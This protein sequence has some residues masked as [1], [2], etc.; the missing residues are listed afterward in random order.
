MVSAVNGAAAFPLPPLFP[1]AAPLHGILWPTA[2]LAVPVP[3]PL[4]VVLQGN[5]W[6]VVTQLTGADLL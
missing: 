2:A 4:L 6:Y 5:L 1:R 3:P